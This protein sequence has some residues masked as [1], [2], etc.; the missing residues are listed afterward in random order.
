MYKKINFINGNVISLDPEH[1]EKI[2]TISIAYGKIHSLNNPINNAKNIDLNG[3]TI[4]PGFVD[5]HFHLKNMGKRLNM[6]DLKS[7]KSIFEIIKKTKDVVNNHLDGEWIFGFGW[8]QTLWDNSEFPTSNILND[9][10]PK[11]PVVFT[12][13]DGHCIWINECTIRKSTYD[14][15]NLIAPDG[16]EIINNCIFVD[17]AMSKINQAIPNEDLSQVKSWIELA[18]NEVIKRGITNVHDAWQDKLI[19]ESIKEIEFENNLPI[20]CYGM[21]SSN[22]KELLNKYFK[23][24]YYKSQL[25][26]IRSVKAFIDGA[27]GS[28]GASLL[29][30]YSDC[31][32]HC[33]LILISK[34]DFDE[35]AYNCNRYNFQLCT[36]AIGDNGNRLVLDSYI[37]NT[38]HNSNHRWRVEHAQMVENSDIEKFIDGRII[39]SMQPSHCTSDMRWLESRIGN[40]RV[41]RISKWKTFVDANVPIAGGSDCPIEDGEPLFEYYAAVTRQDHNGL[42]KGGWQPQEKLDRISALKMFTLWAAYSEFA[43]HKRGMI[44]I[45]YDADLT[46]FSD[47]IT[48]CAV[49][50]I[51]K[52]EAIGTVVGGN[53]VYLNL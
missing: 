51:L 43:E 24:G 47:D 28:R 49:D 2:N 18:I 50:D 22:D 19:I 21:L 13:I 5:S 11:N 10:S 32:N 35:L 38:K 53:V 20:R 46:I 36:H 39:P 16:G 17:N 33:G 44:K 41:D 3:A 4:I 9:I 12:R 8:D 7:C 27:L 15:S 52:T 14:S 40:H 31:S 30:P 37:D 29:E 48:K 6:I 1:S 34:D 42:P 26:T 25:Y 45:G 23:S